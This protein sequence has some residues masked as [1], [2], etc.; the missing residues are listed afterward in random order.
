[1]II[2]PASTNVSTDGTIVVEANQ[3]SLFSI[4]GGTTW[5][6]PDIQGAFYKTFSGLVSAL[7]DVGVKHTQ[8]GCIRFQ[9]VYVPVA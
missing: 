8:S 9:K 6:S 5:V 2:I 4:D 1:M 3:P 7:Y